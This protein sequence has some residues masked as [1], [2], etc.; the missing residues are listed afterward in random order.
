MAI[1]GH[2]IQ[3]RWEKDGKKFSKLEVAVDDI[4]LISRPKNESGETS[5]TEI[6]TKPLETEM[7][8]GELPAN[9]MYSEPKFTEDIY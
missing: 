7:Y 1:E 2:L 9:E 4:K 8:S 3:R 5:P 6:E